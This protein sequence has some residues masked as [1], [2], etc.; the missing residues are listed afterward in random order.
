MSF[1]VQYMLGG[2]AHVSGTDSKNNGGSTVLDATQWLDVQ[3]DSRYSTAK[4]D[5]DSKMEAFFAPV[6]E[7]AKALDEAATPAKLDPIEYVVLNEGVEAVPGQEKEILELTKD[8]IVLRLIDMDDTDRL[9]W[10]SPTEIGVLA[11]S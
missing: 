4:A 2:E 7:A 9:V 11:A 5:F 10:V 6:L 8:S 1:A 3:A